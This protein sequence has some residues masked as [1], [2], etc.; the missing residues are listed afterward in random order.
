MIPKLSRA[1]TG[2]GISEGPHDGPVAI[3]HRDP[4]LTQVGGQRITE[5][6]SNYEECSSTAN[7]LMDVFLKNASKVFAT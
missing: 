1:H 2:V 4:L 6:P 5:L 3:D 7:P